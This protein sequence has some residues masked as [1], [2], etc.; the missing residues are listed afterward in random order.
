MVYRAESR[1]CPACGGALL[2]ASLRWRVE[3][4]AGC[5]GAFVEEAVLAEMMREMGAPAGPTFEAREHGPQRRCPGCAA[6]MAWVALATFPLERCAAHGI[7]FDK[8]E[9]QQ[10][11]HAS[12]P[13]PPGDDGRVTVFDV[14]LGI[15]DILS[16]FP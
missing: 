4:C 11:L 6:P 10:A 16:F 3:S 5:G 15:L 9:L 14:V 7:W 1:P 8:E 2:E 12:A 13:V